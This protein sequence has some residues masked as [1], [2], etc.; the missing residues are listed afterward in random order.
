MTDHAMAKRKKEEE[1]RATIYKMYT[2]KT[3]DW[4]K[5]TLLKLRCAG[6][7]S[8]HCSSSGT[9][10]FIIERNEDHRIW[11]LFWTLVYVNVRYY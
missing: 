1:G 11:K 2:K 10:R 8:N 4:A 5:Q 3:I 7:L 6:S 9:R